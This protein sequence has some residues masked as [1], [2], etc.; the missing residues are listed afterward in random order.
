MPSTRPSQSDKAD[1]FSALH[2]AAGAF[3]I[4][5][6]WDLGT[7]RLLEQSGFPAL[8]TT[9]AGFAFS[10]GQPDNTVSLEALLAHLVELTN[11][12]SVPVSA[13]LENGFGDEP[14]TVARTV[15]LAA[16]AGVVGGSIEDSTGRSSDPLYERAFAVER[17]R[18]AAEAAKALP[19]RF[20]LTARAENF[21]VGRP[22]LADTIARLQAYQEAG[23][24]VLYAP[25]LSRQ[26]DIAQVIREVDRPLNVLIGF[27]SI[28]LGV[29]ELEAMRVKRISVG[30]SL[31][32]AALGEFMRAA[33]ELRDQ[34]TT[35]YSRTAMDGKTLNEMFTSADGSGRSVR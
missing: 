7:A 15:R 8:A 17:I 23:A 14:Q 3:V 13:D 29:R 25:G 26:E 27:T 19:F 32:R 18:A 31:A 33:I 24:D 1:A 35:G 20:T 30:G 12:T 2:H 11:G 4:P 16:E 6:P 22:D 5:N 21:L 10:H 34:G 28:S 9:S